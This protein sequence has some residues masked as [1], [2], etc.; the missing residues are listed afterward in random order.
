MEY[1]KEDKKFILAGSGWYNN[2]LSFYLA[3]K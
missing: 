2:G 3:D 1:F